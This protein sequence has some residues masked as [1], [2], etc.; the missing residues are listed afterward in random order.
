MMDAL[1]NILRVQ[2][3]R[4]NTRHIVAEE[5]RKHTGRDHIRT[6]SDARLLSQGQP[7]DISCPRLCPLS[8]AVRPE[9][10]DIHTQVTY[11]YCILTTTSP[12]CHQKE[13]RKGT[14]VG[15]R[16]KK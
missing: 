10:A 11:W 14:E 15:V 9:V 13:E 2:R 8:P 5:E 16:I 7:Q 3:L 6:A 4:T 1:A 12:V